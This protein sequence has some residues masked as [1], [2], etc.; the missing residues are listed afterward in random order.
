LWRRVGWKMKII[1]N[2]KEEV[3]QGFRKEE[4]DI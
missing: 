2:E 3:E 4:E 1:L